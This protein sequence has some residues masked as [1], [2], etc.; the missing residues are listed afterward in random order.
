MSDKQSMVLGG[1]GV[2]IIVSI[3][4]LFPNHSHHKA[5]PQQRYLSFGWK[6]YAN[7]F[8]YMLKNFYIWIFMGD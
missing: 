3:Y 8:R 2:R 1:E 4:V 6:A 5:G 7:V